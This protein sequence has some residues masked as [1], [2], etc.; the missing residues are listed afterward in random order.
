[1]NNEVTGTRA[2]SSP[3]NNSN[4]SGYKRI[5]D[6]SFDDLS[7]DELKEGTTYSGNIKE[8]YVMQRDTNENAIILK[9]SRDD[10]GEN[11]ESWNNLNYKFSPIRKLVEEVKR[12]SGCSVAPQDLIGLQVEF[13]VKYHKG[14]CNLKTINQVANED[15]PHSK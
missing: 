11:Y 6:F 2:V 14:Y 5:T 10:N 7:S 1:M 4:N 12:A 13:T 9:I 8:C 15:I 3:E